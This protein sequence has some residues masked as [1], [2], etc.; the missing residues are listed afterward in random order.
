MKDR[1]NY[2]NKIIHK[3]ERG[4][5]KDV[6]E[7]KNYRFLV[8]FGLTGIR[9]FSKVVEIPKAIILPIIIVLSVIGAYSINQNVYDI[10][11]MIAFGV[12]GYF[13][14]M[15]DYP[16][17]TMVLG[18]ILSPII[19]ANFRRAVA[20]EHGS[21]WGFAVSLFT[22]PISLIL[23]MFIIFMV[24]YQAKSKYKKTV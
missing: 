23:L 21:L 17:A 11:W 2:T 18:V 14:K 12:L 20:M 5:L 8:F 13:M 22:H 24:L 7:Q 4:G 6:F 1:S 3:I 9:I 10:Y 19:D 15:Y 16:V